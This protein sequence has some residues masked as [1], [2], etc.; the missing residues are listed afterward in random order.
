[1][2]TT[3]YQAL[4]A[5]HPPYANC[6]FSEPRC[7]EQLCGAREVQ[8]DP[9]DDEGKP[10]PSLTL[11]TVGYC[12]CFFSSAPFTV[13]VG[14]QGKKI[15]LEAWDLAE[16]LKVGPTLIAKYARTNDLAGLVK[17]AF[18]AQHPEQAVAAAV[19]R[20]KDLYFPSSLYHIPLTV[21]AGKNGHLFFGSS[22]L[23]GSGSFA[24]VME[25]KTP[26]G[27]KVA[28]RILPISEGREEKTERALQFMR[29]VC[30]REGVIDLLGEFRYTPEGGTPTLVTFHSLFKKNLSD[31]F[32]EHR[33]LNWQTKISYASQL[34]QGLLSLRPAAHADLK[35]QNVVLDEEEKVLKIIDLDMHRTPED[36]GKHRRG[37]TDW[38]SPEVLKDGKVDVRNLDVW[39]LGLILFGLWGDLRDVPWMLKS[40]DVKTSE[41]MIKACEQET[42]NAMIRKRKFPQPLEDLLL[43]MQ[44]VDP[45]SRIFLEEAADLFEKQVATL[46]DPATARKT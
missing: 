46:P 5:D 18:W 28:C 6:R 34:F 33:H 43:K 8:L 32:A 35:S 21:Y 42:M 16:R 27:K 4:G 3:P 17:R 14:K 13:T 37:S 39:A 22:N 24:T 15:D 20:K 23:V 26:D 45:K 25:G 10:L 1:M 12:S 31:I 29:T 2:S 11:R 7:L 40:V 9:V 30:G 19:R 41:K 36:V 44:V 38:F